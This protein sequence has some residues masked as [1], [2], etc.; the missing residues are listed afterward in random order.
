MTVVAVL[1]H[2]CHCEAMLRGLVSRSSFEKAAKPGGETAV[3]DQFL[4]ARWIVRTEMPRFGHV[5]NEAQDAFSV[6]LAVLMR[7]GLCGKHVCGRAP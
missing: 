2:I 3:Q 7:I 4:Q 1:A 6:V 5:P